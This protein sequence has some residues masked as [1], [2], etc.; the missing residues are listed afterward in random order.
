MKIPVRWSTQTCFFSARVSEHW[1][2]G[3][4]D[5][6]SICLVEVSIR[7]QKILLNW[8][9]HVFQGDIQ[10]LKP[11]ASY[12]LELRRL[13]DAL[14]S[15]RESICFMGAVRFRERG[16]IS[17]IGDTRDTI[18]YLKRLPSQARWKI[19]LKRWRYR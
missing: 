2:D 5:L 16:T 1:S 17:G 7:R 19:F 14:S 18:I 6:H 11:S 8:Q 12:F 9:L 4:N 3:F 15:D 13:F 10:V